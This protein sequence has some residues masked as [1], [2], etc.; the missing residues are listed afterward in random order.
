MKN[1]N[2][3]T[4]RNYAQRLDKQ[5][6]LSHYRSKFLFP[7]DKN[8]FSCI[9]LCGNSL[10]LQ[11]KSVSEYLTAELND[12]SKYG[13]HGH[14]KAGRPW[15]NY[16][17]QAREGFAS[18]TGRLQ[19]EVIAMNTLTVNL[20]MLMT[21]FY[22]PNNKRF[23]ILIE[24]TAFP[25]DRFAAESQIRLHGYDPKEA[26][27]EWVPKNDELFLGDLQQIIDKEGDEIALILVPG[28]QYY[29]GQVMPMQEICQIARTAGCK[30]GLDLAHAVGNIELDLHKWAPD[31]AAWC[32]Y[33]YLNGGPGSVGGAFIHEMHHGGNGDGQ[34]LGWWSNDLETRFKMGTEFVAAKDA[35]LWQVSNP[36]VFSLTPVIASLH[37]FKEASFEKLRE[38]SI[39][40]T[41][42]LDF[43]IQNTFAGQVES[44]TPI[45]K[46][47]CQL[48]LVIRDN[49]FNGKAVFNSLTDKNV[50]G[51]WREPN[52]IRMAPTPLYNSY[53]DVYEF[54][55]RL[56]ES[57]A[58]N[59]N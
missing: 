14:T 18:L 50:I 10:G 38:K 3:E 27:I 15:L 51:D 31:F 9:Y 21:T 56:K 29:S 42:Y 45:Y 26:L 55:D 43:L 17:L 49:T 6:E 44:I 8:G 58:E 28:I 13:V 54:V 34:L 30:I 40:L 48:S 7:E 16:H 53:E 39:Q 52:V 37:M 59:K 25:S 46:R 23:K 1:F 5:D 41:S 20:H 4:N 11:P 47:G 12:W 36:P 22:R 32:T 24:S 35:D 19:H 33:K 2:F 57:V